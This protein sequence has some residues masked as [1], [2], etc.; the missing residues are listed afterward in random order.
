MDVDEREPN[1][2]GKA[3]MTALEKAVHRRRNKRKRSHEDVKLAPRYYRHMLAPQRTAGSGVDGD[4]D[5][6]MGGT[7]DQPAREDSLEAGEIDETPTTNY[8]ME[9]LKREPQTSRE[10]IAYAKHLLL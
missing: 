1:F 9:I 4:G 5:A 2:E 8:D 6:V 3:I 10:K 7:T